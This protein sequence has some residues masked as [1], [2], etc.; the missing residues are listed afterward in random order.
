M[1][2]WF[3][4]PAC[5]LGPELNVAG[6]AS[7]SSKGYGKGDNSMVVGYVLLSIQAWELDVV[8]Q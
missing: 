4:L 6:V 3:S 8:N 2:A 1:P 7:G 5:F